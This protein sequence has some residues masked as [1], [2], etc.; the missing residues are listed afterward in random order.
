MKQFYKVGGWYFVQNP[1]IAGTWLRV[2]RS[3]SV[4]CPVCK[5]NPL[6]P[7]ASRFS[8]A[9]GMTHNMRRVYFRQYEA[10]SRQLDR[11]EKRDIA[12]DVARIKGDIDKLARA[13]IEELLAKDKI[14]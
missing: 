3:I 6:S 14:R 13:S 8:A 7:C 11:A 10:L 4:A 2:D 5:A 12:E 1:T 9:G